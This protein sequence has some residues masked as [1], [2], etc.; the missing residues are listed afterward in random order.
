MFGRSYVVRFR[1]IHQTECCRNLFTGE[2]VFLSTS[3]EARPMQIFEDDPD[4][5]L[6]PFCK[7]N[8]HERPR[9]HYSSEDGRVRVF[10]NK[11]PI[12]TEHGDYPGFHDVLIDT[13][14]HK[15]Q[16]CDFSDPHV[17]Q[18]LQFLQKRERELWL[19]DRVKVV[20]TFKN[21]GKYAG[22]SI[23]HSHWQIVAIPFVPDY[24][25]EQ[26]LKYH[27][28]QNLVCPICDF[29]ADEQT[30]I[31]EDENIRA[32]VPEFARFAYEIC[33]T[34]KRHVERFGELTDAELYG[35]GYALKRGL[36][37][38]RGLLNA[39]DTNILFHNGFDG[40]GGFMHF[41]ASIV[42]RMG[43]LAGFELTTGCFVHSVKAERAAK[44]IRE[45]FE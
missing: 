9:D 14:I 1:V 24:Q 45:R 32:F 15:E 38:I 44:E 29:S 11:Y 4:G 19:D 25:R 2:V 39:P 36:R 35:L 13:D 30:L 16:F 12:L 26:L 41:H 6:C 20:Q 28:G 21:Q 3:R 37:A 34:T 27:C 23:A 40:S 5:K 31:Y 18:T 17:L 43:F 8:A 22:A 10:P 33:V 7:H 42:P